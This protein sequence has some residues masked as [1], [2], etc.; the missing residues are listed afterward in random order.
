MLV[1]PRL[2]SKIELILV[3][4]AE[5]RNELPPKSQ[6][7]PKK[8]WKPGLDSRLVDKVRKEKGKQTILV[9]VNKL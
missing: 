7:L 6:L 5:G 3:Q 1:P 8:E 9:F 4:Q 2:R